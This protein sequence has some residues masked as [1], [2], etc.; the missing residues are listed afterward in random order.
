MYLWCVPVFV[1]RI[2]MY[3]KGI[4][5][6]TVPVPVQVFIYQE[7]EEIQEVSQVFRTTGPLL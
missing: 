3:E 4:E 5:L 2:Y 1:N 6:I 7:E